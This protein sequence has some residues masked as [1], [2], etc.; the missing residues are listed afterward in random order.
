MTPEER[1]AWFRA[2]VELGDDPVGLAEAIKAA[3]GHDF[4]AKVAD[5]LITW[6]VVEPWDDE[7]DEARKE[8]EDRW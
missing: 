6:I 3:F 8:W 7:E 2:L 1:A 4:A 5:A